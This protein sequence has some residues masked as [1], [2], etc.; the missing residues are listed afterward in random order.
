MSENVIEN[1]DVFCTVVEEVVEKIKEVL[2][3][4]IAIESKDKCI[5]PIPKPIKKMKTPSPEKKAK[6]CKKI[7][8]QKDKIKQKNCFISPVVSQPSSSDKPCKP[9]HDESAT[10]KKNKQKLNKNEPKFKEKNA[11][12]KYGNYNR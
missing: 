9:K 8:E 3:S 5:S 11:L 6:D 12:F 10:S 1:N 7:H 2:E 4:E